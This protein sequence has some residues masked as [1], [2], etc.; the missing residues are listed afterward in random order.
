MRLV[1][2]T[3]NVDILEP[4][5]LLHALNTATPTKL[6][7]GHQMARGMLVAECGT[8][9][10]GMLTR[11]QAKA[12][13]ITFPNARGQFDQKE[14]LLCQASDPRVPVPSFDFSRVAILVNPFTQRGLRAYPKGGAGQSALT[15][16]EGAYCCCRG[17]F[18]TIAANLNF[19]AIA[20]SARHDACKIYFHQLRKTSTRAN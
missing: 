8:T 1:A 10:N 7:S 5:R 12:I 18:S 15:L 16:T 4:C 17:G 11:V 19:Q 3:I 20:S 6:P 2:N 14:N 13:A 9:Q